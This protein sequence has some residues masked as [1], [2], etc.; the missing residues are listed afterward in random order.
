[1]QLLA[2]SEILNRMIAAF[3]WMLIH[4]L[5]QGIV[6]ALVTIILMTL[7]KKWPAFARYNMVLAF[8]AGFLFISIIT[9]LWELNNVYSSNTNGSFAIMSAA[10]I[11]GFFFGGMETMRQVLNK[12]SLYCTEHATFIAMIWFIIFG[13]RIIKIQGALIYNNRIKNRQIVQPNLYW[14]NRM[15]TLRSLLNIRKAVVLFES[16]YMKVPVVIGHLKPVILMPLGLLTSLPAQQ[17]EAILLHELAHIRRNDYL[18]NIF[19]HIAETVFF[20]NPAV[21]WVS[22]WLKEEREN[23]CD[24]IALA[25]TQ[26]KEGLIEAL[27]SFKQHELYGSFYATAFPGRKDH[28]LRRVGHILGN[29]N[30]TA[31]LPVKIFYGAAFILLLAGAATII[32]SQGTRPVAAKK[33]RVSGKVSSPLSKVIIVEPVEIKPRIY[34]KVVGTAGQTAFEKGHTVFAPKQSDEKQEAFLGDAQMDAENKEQVVKDEVNAKLDAEKA[35][36]DQQNAMIDEK[37]A[38]K[39]QKQ[40]IINQYNA[41]LAQQKAMQDQLRAKAD[42][43][44]ADLNQENALRNKKEAEKI[45]IQNQSLQ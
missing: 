19:Q 22:S 42:A 41:K 20:F 11:P 38:K 29:N 21:L 2:T 10:H 1:M 6:L 32:L 34:K 17:V 39:D 36:R 26:N 13:T 23:C 16:G 43:D 44:M 15:N 45:K 12:I 24:D 7:T 3:S 35:F 5:W 40:A 31:A 28:L 18:V 25:Q 37:K 33:F 30:T 4:S 8:F 9:F 27:I 14:R